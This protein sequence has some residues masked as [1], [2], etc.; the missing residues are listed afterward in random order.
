M[1]N[2][3]SQQPISSDT[4]VVFNYLCGSKIGNITERTKAITNGMTA[5]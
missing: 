4:N 2:V 5:A 1:Q 3:F